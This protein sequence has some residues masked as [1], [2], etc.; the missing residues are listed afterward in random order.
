MC[1]L[2]LSFTIDAMVSDVSLAMSLPISVSASMSVSFIA[3]SVAAFTPV[4]IPHESSR[5]PTFFAFSLK[6]ELSALS[7]ACWSMYE[8]IAPAIT[9]KA[10]LV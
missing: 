5:I 3:P 7:S 2:S 8:V 1:A 4:F 9:M 6:F 10:S